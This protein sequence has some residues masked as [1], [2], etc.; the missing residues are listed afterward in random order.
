M[1]RTK[2]EQADPDA[3]RI[4]DLVIVPYP[5]A[6]ERY[7]CPAEAGLLLE[8]RRSSVKVFF[9]EPDCTLWLDRHKVRRVLPDEL[10]VHPLVG[11]AHAVARLLDAEEVTVH[12]RTPER[13][14]VRFSF[15]GAD[16]ALLEAV[17][18]AAGPGLVSLRVEAGSMRHVRLDLVLRPSSGGPG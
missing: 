11:T 5:E 15:A 9:A 4:G 12:E 7:G 10:E 14:E 18:A 17:E 8:D 2:G 1:G 3:P 13:V 16:L 6:R